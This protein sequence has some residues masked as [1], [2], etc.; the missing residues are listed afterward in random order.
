[1]YFREAGDDSEESGSS[2]AEDSGE[3]EAVSSDEEEVEETPA[4][5]SY[6]ALMQSLSAENGPQAKRRKLN[7]SETPKFQEPEKNETPSEAQ[8]DVDHVE[9]A[10][11]GPE[12]AVEGLVEDE[13]ETEDSTDPF[14]AHFA[15]PDENSL[16]AK[17]R[18]LQQSQWSTR[19]TVIPDVGKVNISLPGEQSSESAGTN[20]KTLGPKDLK[21]KQKLATVFLKDKSSFDPL[22]SNV[23]NTMF[24]Y[25]DMLFCGRTTGNSQNLRRLTCLHAVNHVFK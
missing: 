18:A 14:E 23:A 9:E 22:E 8:A 13:D 5:R 25:Q 16:A 24:N 20:N 15:S 11:E 6:A 2:E 10:E 17:L 12:T 19:N 7:N 4:T 3:E 21:L 1:M